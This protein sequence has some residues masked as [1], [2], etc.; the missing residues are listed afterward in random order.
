MHELHV[1][2]VSGNRLE[3]LPIEIGQCNLKAIW[4]AENQSQPL[5]KYQQEIDEKT[6][7]KVLT[8]YLLP[9]QG[10]SEHLGKNIA[11]ALWARIGKNTDKIA[12]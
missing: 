12:V 9:Q 11:A 4:L 7:Q 8:C 5:L 1:L 3:H 10:F 2:D 6:G